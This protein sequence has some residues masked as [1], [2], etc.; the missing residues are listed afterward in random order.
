MKEIEVIYHKASKK[1]APIIFT[2]HGFD[3]NMDDYTYDDFM[4]KMISEEFSCN[5]VSIFLAKF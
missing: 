1:N 5:V 4:L 2:T 3:F